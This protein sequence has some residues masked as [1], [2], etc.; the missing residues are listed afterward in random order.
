MSKVSTTET[1]RPL[2]RRS[3]VGA[4]IG[5]L[6][7][8]LVS[9]T[10][11]RMDQLGISDFD[12]LWKQLQA[13]CNRPIWRAFC[14]S[15]W[16]EL[17]GTTGQIDL[18]PLPLPPEMLIEA[19]H[20]VFPSSVS[21]NDLA[22]VGCGWRLRLAAQGKDLFDASL[23]TIEGNVSWPFPRPLHVLAEHDLTIQLH[24]DAFAAQAPVPLSVILAGAVR[25][26]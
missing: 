3:F 9:D 19:V 8:P 5:A 13:E 6:A 15:E 2:P 14:V 18:F 1:V 12:G 7:L 23:N 4:L 20:V 17:S 26:A 22:R 21:C 25:L 16:A 11:H 10:T 24:G